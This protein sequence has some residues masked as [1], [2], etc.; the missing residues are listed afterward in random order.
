MQTKL[1]LR[2]DEELIRKAKQFS[3]TTG[4]SLSRIVADYFGKLDESQP[5]EL[6]D[7][8]PKVAALLGILKGTGADK[9]DWCRHLEEKHL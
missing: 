9:D 5:E 6:E 3:R 8:T 2:M 7:I 1:T 4:K